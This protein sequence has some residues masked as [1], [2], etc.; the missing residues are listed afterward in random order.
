VT[1]TPLRPVRL[2]ERVEP[3]LRLSN[4]CEISVIVPALNEAK[5]LPALMAQIRRALLGR[6]YEVI[7]VDDDSA[8]ET[9][10]V[11][12][13]LA[14]KH[15]LRLVVRH[16]VS[17]G[18]SGAVLHGMSL[19]RGDKLVVMDADLQ[20][21]PQKIPELLAR[22]E[23]GD[24]DF[25]L[26]S[27]YIEGASTGEKWGLFRRLNSSVATWLAR[28]FAGGT[29]DPMSGF[30]AMHRETY[31]RAKR[32]SP[33]GYKIALELI[34]KCRARRIAEVPIHF[35]QRTAGE[36]KLN[37]KQQARYLRHLGRLYAFTFP[38]TALLG[39]AILG[40]AAG[41]GFGQ[42]TNPLLAS[43]LGV[44]TSIALV[45][46]TRDRASLPPRRQLLEAERVFRFVDLEELRKAA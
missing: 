36:S 8:D 39:K 28:P 44:M 18:L 35:G 31:R 32:L 38:R 5:N 40:A 14:R 34:C 30:F 2:T 19:A 26:G 17:D 13:T 25:V 29:S 16:R 4:D 45:F 6:P 11:C 21:P 42:F 33:L 22:L 23:S 37:L 43:T 15:P 1:I 3:H 9:P 7:I 20:H 10:A 24:A 12:E 46:A 27:R 41:W